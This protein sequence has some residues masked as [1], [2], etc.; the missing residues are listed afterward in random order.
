MILASLLVVS[1]L[2]GFQSD[3]YAQARRGDS[4]SSSGPS[5]S[6]SVQKPSSNTPASKS[7]AV[8]GGTQTRPSGSAS[9]PSGTAVRPSGQTSKPSGSVSRPSGATTRPSGQ[10]NK[11]SGSVSRPSGQQSRPNGGSVSKPA[12]KPSG[13]PSTGVGGRPNPG[14]KPGNQN[15]PIGVTRPGSRPTDRP[16]NGPSHR[17]AKPSG[18]MAGTPHRPSRPAGVK[19]PNRPPIYVYPKP[20]YRPNYGPRPPRPRPGVIIRPYYGTVIAHNI[21]ASMAWTAV[22]LAYYSSVARTYSLISDNNAYIAEQNAVIAQNNA[23]I[24]AQN[25]A[26]AQSDALAQSAYE[27]AQRL[28]LVQSFAA[29]DMEYYYQNGVFYVLDVDGE[30]RVI[31]PPAGALV[32]SLPS[33]RT[34][35]TLG[36]EVLY[37]VDDTIY[38]SRNIDGE[39]Y[40]EVLGQLYE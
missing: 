7:P 39:L 26:I 35:V 10:Q 20:V 6:T 31:I 27:K 23:I 40:F 22:R 4:R 13:K 37:K 17:P 29:A 28:G 32:D 30:Y 11:P 34:T 36:G 5:R 24:A 15:K 18:P 8:S 21:A 14:Y 16:Q 12:D 19:V 9:R 1:A 33:D 2:S 25:Q 3:A 38:Q